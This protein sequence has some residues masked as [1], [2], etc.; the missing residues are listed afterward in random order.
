MPPSRQAS[1]LALLLLPLAV[2]T[3]A[4]CGGGTPSPVALQAPAQHLLVQVGQVDVQGEVGA[5]VDPSSVTL[6]LDGVD[7]IGALGLVPPFTGAGGMVLVGADL[8]TVSDLTYEPVS[9]Q[10]VPIAAHLEGLPLGGHRVELRGLRSS[11]GSAVMRSRDF[12]AARPLAE[13]VHVVPSAGLRAPVAAGANLHLADAALGDP[14]ATSPQVQ[15]DG[16]SLR[17]GFVEAAEARIAGGSPP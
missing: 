5:V 12:E 1:A 9:G 6:S 17:S 3:G 2:V 7:V 14:L 11:D 10:R 16:S 8:V 4:R 13:A 15:T